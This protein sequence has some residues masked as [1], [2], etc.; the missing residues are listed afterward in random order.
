[1]CAR[2]KRVGVVMGGLSSE[3]DISLKS[4][5]AVLRA[6]KDTGWQALA[7]DVLQET[8]EEVQ[9]LV[10]EACVDVVFVAMH[11]GFGEDGRLQKILEEMGVAFTGPAPEASRLA[12]DKVASRRLFERAGLCV[13]RTR[14]IRR[15]ERMM[16]LLHELQY[17][18]VIKPA[19]Q[20][21]SIGVTCVT[22]WREL[23]PAV[24]KALRYDD[25]ILVEEFIKGREIAV[26]VLDGTAL[27]V[28]AIIPKNTLFD[29]QA[30]YE[31]GMTEYVVP[32]SLDAALAERAQQ[33]AVTA[34]E[35]LGCRHLARA[36]MILD[37]EG[38]VVMLEVNTVPGLTETSLLPKAARAAG[39]EFPSLCAK[40]VELAL[41]P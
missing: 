27:P 9:R 41:N 35:A 30:K 38:R 7:L 32:A 18:V 36:D 8:Q 22:H 3:R 17:P 21:S 25:T 31:K 40:I 14:V 6:L 33:D 19:A 29:F 2:P 5:R 15:A 34:Y 20:G 4:G 13:P 11:G 23:A 12:M 39:L 10:R 16:S 24:L 1:M 26:S 28:V 37:K